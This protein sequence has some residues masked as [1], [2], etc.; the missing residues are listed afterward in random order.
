MMK[1]FIV[2]DEMNNIIG[3][4]K[5]LLDYCHDVELLGYSQSVE[6][7]VLRLRQLQPDCILMD[8][9]LPDGTGF[10][11]LQQLPDCTSKIIFITAYDKYAVKA[12]K[13][14]AIDYLLKPIHKDEL[15]NAL[16]KVQVEPL[17]PLPPKGFHLKGKLPVP[18]I[19]G[20]LLL[21]IK[22]IVR[23]EASDNYSKIVMNGGKEFI[24]SRTLSVIEEFLVSDGFLRVHR[25]HLINPNFVTFLE[26]G[27][28]ALITLANGNQVPWS[29]KYRKNIYSNFGQL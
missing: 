6:D 20:V 4:E 23:C 10:D 22:D 9:Q 8:I 2:E 5:V 24:A 7:A 11:I 18:T 17:I 21:D 19:N 26:K 29:D 16:K 3:L 27:K 25:S 13:F 12:F 28:N 14:S 1:V 15:V